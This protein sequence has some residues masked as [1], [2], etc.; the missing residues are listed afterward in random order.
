MGLN[1][2]R[3]HVSSLDLLGHSVSIS[4][5][6]SKV[7][8]IMPTLQGFHEDKGVCLPVCSLIHLFIF[9]ILSD[10]RKKR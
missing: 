6:D 3:P 1:L 10:S 7:A 9:H 8:I 5:S 2:V 4:S